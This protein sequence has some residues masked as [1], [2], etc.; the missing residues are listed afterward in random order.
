MMAGQKGS[1]FWG[2]QILSI[3]ALFLLQSRPPSPHPA[4]PADRPDWWEVRV[5]LQAEGDYK[6]DAGGPSAVGHL[7]FAVLWTG[8]LEKDDQD[9][10]LY[11]LDCRLCDW[12]ARE[13]FFLPEAT[14]VLTTNDFPDKP[15][16]NLK[17]FI[18]V[19]DTLRLDFLIDGLAVPLAHGKEVFTLLLP[20]SQQN[21]QKS[22]D[23]DY[24]DGIIKGSNRVEVPE[25]EIYSGPVDKAYAWAWENQQ[26]LLRQQ[27]AVFTSQ[28]HKVQVSLKITPHKARPR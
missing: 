15:G 11:R 12:E 1:S 25:E 13:T 10:L 26:W 21:N 17:Y 28:S 22:A 16:F 27:R 19:G 14:K 4:S 18:R 5:Y 7:A 8:W 9:Y 24:N 6:L 3:V 20:S 23:I 2:C